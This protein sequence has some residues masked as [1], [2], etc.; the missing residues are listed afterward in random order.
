M[1]LICPER[2]NAMKQSIRGVSQASRSLQ[3][4]ELEINKHF[5]RPAS[6]VTPAARFASLSATWQ[7]D[8]RL[9]SSAQQIATHPAYQEIIGM[10]TEALPLI[11]RELAESPGHWFWALRAIA[12]ESPIR[13]EDRGNVPAMRDA[14][15]AWGR[16]RGYID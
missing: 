2:P 6:R 10:G 15:L 1:S 7:D 3:V 9:V 14:W 11:L 4:A 5:R 13:P 8:T 12:G 16:K